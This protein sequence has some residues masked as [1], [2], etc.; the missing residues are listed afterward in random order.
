MN[1]SRS[2]FLRHPPTQLLHTRAR[3]E[4]CIRSHLHWGR[5]RYEYIFWTLTAF[6]DRSA[7]PFK[8][9]VDSLAWGSYA[10]FVSE[11]SFR[12]GMSVSKNFAARLLRLP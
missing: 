8:K 11:S 7:A 10:W 1:A 3:G 9:V 12:P 6:L 5:G 4:H 2:F